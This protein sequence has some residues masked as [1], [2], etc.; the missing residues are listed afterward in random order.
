M[1]PENDDKPVTHAYLR[2]VLIKV[3]ESLQE[4][5]GAIKKLQQPSEDNGPSGD[6]IL[7]VEKQIGLLHDK[8]QEAIRDDQRDDRGQ[9]NLQNDIQRIET[10]L[11]QVERLEKDEEYDQ[12]NIERE[13]KQLQ[14]DFREIERKIHDIEYKLNRLWVVAVEDQQCVC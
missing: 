14:L 6:R 2:E 8:I 1:P 13:I 4:F 3:D 10:R 9:N 11:E 5:S 7:E 12:N